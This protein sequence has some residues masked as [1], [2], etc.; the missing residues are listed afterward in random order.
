MKESILHSAE[1]KKD[2]SRLEGRTQCP[3]ILL[4]EGSISALE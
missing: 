4:V 2:G 1:F 3:D